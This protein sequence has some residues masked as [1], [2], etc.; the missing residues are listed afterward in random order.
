MLKA[1]IKLYTFPFSQAGGKTHTTK[2]VCDRHDPSFV[3]K[4]NF[5]IKDPVYAKLS[6]DIIDKSN[7]FSERVIGSIELNVSN[8]TG[9]Y[10]YEN[11][12]L[13]EGKYGECY[14]AFDATWHIVSN[15]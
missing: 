14:V 9:G 3:D 6:V 1:N 7:I 10:D 4:I 15:N 11:E 12:Y 8:Y 13:L 2:V 5:V